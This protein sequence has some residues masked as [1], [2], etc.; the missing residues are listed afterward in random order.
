MIESLDQ[1][2]EWN[3]VEALVRAAGGYVHPSEELRPRVLEAA[4]AE[5]RERRAQRQIWHLAIVIALLGALSTAIVGHW[6][7][8][9]P[10]SSA[11]Y[12]ASLLQ[13]QANARQAEGSDAGWS[14]VESFTDLR[15]RQAALLSLTK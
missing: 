7:A 11:P 1:Q 13:M 6:R 10:Y 4:R 2:S 14:M 12:S 8:A 9:A 3:D 15:R 5:S